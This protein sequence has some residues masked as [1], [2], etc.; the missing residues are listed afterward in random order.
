MN[1]KRI[2]TWI[3]NAVVNC[4]LVVGALVAVGVC[5]LAMLD[6]DAMMRLFQR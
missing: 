3:I 1:R 2:T 5:A 4:V 6:F